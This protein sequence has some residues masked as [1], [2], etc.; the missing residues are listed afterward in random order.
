MEHGTQ[1]AET[2]TK[3]KKGLKEI[4]KIIDMCITKQSFKSLVQLLLLE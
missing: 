2:K 3:M 4:D 1:E